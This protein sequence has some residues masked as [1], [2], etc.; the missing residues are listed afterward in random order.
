ML[1]KL[2]RQAAE[3]MFV[4]SVFS[5]YLYTGNS[6]TQTI[7]N[8]IDLAGEGG[9]FWAKS[10]SAAAGHIL[11]DTERGGAN[12]L[13][14]E[15][16]NAQGDGTASGR[17][18]TFNSDG[19]TLGADTNG[20]L[21]YSAR[22]YVG[23]TF[24]KARKFFDVVTYTGTGSA[25]TVAHNLGS[26]PGMII[27]KRTDTTGDWQVYH[28]SLTSAAYKLVLNTT[29]A[30]ASDSTAWNGTAP[31]D[32]VFSVGTN[33]TVNASGGAYVAYLFAHEAGGFGAD[34]TEDI[35]SCGSFTTDGSGNATVNLG[36]EPQY[37]M[38]KRSDYATGGAWQL[39]DTMRGMSLTNCTQLQAQSSAAD[40]G[41]IGSGVWP[42]ATGF[43]GD[44]TVFY[45][46]ATYI[47]MAIRR[48]MKVPTVGTEVFA[49]DTRGAGSPAFTS[50][51]PVDM[52]LYR[53][54]SYATDTF[55]AARLQG[56]AG[57]YTNLTS[58][59]SANS[60]SFYDYM[61][62]WFEQFS[63]LSTQYAWMFKR[64]PGFFDVVCYTGDG[65]AGRTVNHNLGVA[66]EL[67]LVKGRSG[68]TAWAVY[69]GDSTDYMVLNTTAATVDDA[70]YWNDTTPTASVFSIGTQANVNTSS[71]TYVAHLF[72][73]LPGVSK[74]GSYTGT[75]TTLAIDCGFSAGARFVMIK[76]TDSTG[77][78]YVWDS[79]RGIVAGND[80]YL[81]LNTMDA[82]VT[83]T[84][85]V[86]TYSA[87]FEISSTAPAAINASGGT[88]IYLAIA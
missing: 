44:P 3:P 78:W 49:I 38:V 27:V 35:I 52:T 25:R 29:A 36:W 69:Y 84:D 20:T 71:A 8:G 34:G 10:R 32:A 39:Y 63:A 75:G 46:S 81:R 42:T 45:G 58:A 4:E 55:L 48:P 79:A 40:S 51:F 26:V 18:V 74:V 82:E 41:P 15:S 11:F 57:C 85:Y 73:T 60:R 61:D 33:A 62:G 77:D 22:T 53:D 21:N 68:A 6:S 87:G 64:A 88:F 7:T 37:L 14:S 2:L 16:T 1:S 83:G 13:A 9:L 17:T 50:G 28:R 31:T 65:V 56:T 76:R 30:Q 54:I 66:P 86:D 43:T 70:T 59:E 24:R 5:T 72:A 47:Y 12:Y 80:P 23:W 67:M 19:L